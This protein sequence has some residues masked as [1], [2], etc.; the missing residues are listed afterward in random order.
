MN[1]DII[2]AMFGYKFNKHY[3]EFNQ[4]DGE[5][6]YR[7]MNSTIRIIDYGD[8]LYHKTICPDSCATEYRILYYKDSLTVA[9]T[10]ARFYDMYVGP[11]NR[12]DRRGNLIGTKNTDAPFNYS[13]DDVVNWVKEKHDVD[14]Y[15]K[16]K[17]A[18]MSRSP[19]PFPHYML[20]FLDNN[21]TPIVYSIDA[22]DGSLIFQNIDGVKTKFKDDSI[23]DPKKKEKKKG[24]PTRHRK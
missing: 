21:G 3:F 24:V 17:W 13:K 10:L 2:V 20:R 11:I 9:L 8:S 6:E 12:Y 22:R 16:P 5:L 18:L 1:N 15:K 7:D 19:T 4:K 23:W 14:L